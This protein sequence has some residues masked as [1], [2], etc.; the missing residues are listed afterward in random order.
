MDDRGREAGAGTG[1][2]HLGISWNAGLTATLPQAPFRTR[3][4][5]DP[6]CY[7]SGRAAQGPRGV[8]VQRAGGGGTPRKSSLERDRK[9]W[10]AVWGPEVG[11]YTEGATNCVSGTA[12]R[13]HLTRSPPGNSPGT[14]TCPA[15]FPP[16]RPS[17]S[18]PSAL[19]VQAG[20]SL[21]PAHPLP[22]LKLKR[23][24]GLRE[25]PRETQ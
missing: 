24:A 18:C 25:G 2:P 22:F 10:T 7:P 6:T 16:L 14:H 9:M 17:V 1:T 8:E 12:P 15:S 3:D 11:G 13:Q 4:S 19:T 20:S 23:L 5:A 21:F